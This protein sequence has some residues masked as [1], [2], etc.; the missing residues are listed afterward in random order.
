[1]VFLVRLM[2]PAMKVHES[3]GRHA[4]PAVKPQKF[5]THKNTQ[6]LVKTSECRSLSNGF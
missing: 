2:Y 4:K 5:A 1:M 3:V 6:D